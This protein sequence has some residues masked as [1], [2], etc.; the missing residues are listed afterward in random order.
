MSKIL[1]VQQPINNKNYLINGNF[2][3]WQRGTSTTTG[4]VVYSTAD[5]WWH[6]G[7]FTTWGLSQVADTTNGS[8]YAMRMTV[9]TIGAGTEL[10]IAQPLETVSVLP[11]QGKVVTLSCLLKPN[12]SFTGSCNLS[13]KWGTGTDERNPTGGAVITK[14]IQ[15]SNLSTSQY[16]RVFS[17]FTIPSNATSLAIIVDMLTANIQ[18]GSTLDVKSVM[19]TEGTGFTPFQTAGINIADE[20]AMCQRYYWKRVSVATNEYFATAQATSATNV[21]VFKQLPVPMRTNPTVA[22]NTFSVNQAN[23]ATTSMGATSQISYTPD[24]LTFNG[25]VTGMV[26]GNMALVLFPSIGGSIAADAEL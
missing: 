3:I 19:L 18:N 2:D 11:L 17:T 5:R 7:D 10:V 14:T 1:G 25:A 16:T 20:L 21:T 12:A 9:T 23:G 6:Y 8:K 26:A 13:A 15:M 4:A 22:F 24:A